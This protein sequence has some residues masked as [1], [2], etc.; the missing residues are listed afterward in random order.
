MRREKVFILQPTL[1]KIQEYE[2]SQRPVETSSKQ[3]SFGPVSQ[4]E[5]ELSSPAESPTR[6]TSSESSY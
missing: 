6:Q 2:E 4:E 1:E 5:Y 3:V